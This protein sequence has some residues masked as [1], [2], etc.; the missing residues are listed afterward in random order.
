MGARTGEDPM[1]IGILGNAGVGKS[2]SADHLAQKWE[3]ASIAFADP[4]KRFCKEIFNFSVEQLWGPSE[5][6]N[7]ED[8][9]YP[10]GT[11]YLTPRHALQ[12]LGTQ[13]GRDCYP[14]VW[15]E[16]AIRTAQSI[17]ID[18]CYYTPERGA[19][20]A[21][22]PSWPSHRKGVVISDCRFPNEVAAIH[23]AGGKVIR[24]LRPSLKTSTQTH[25][26]ETEQKDIVVDE[27]IINDHDFEALYRKLDLF[28]VQ[29]RGRYA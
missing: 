10:R 28:I 25:A 2:V 17:L 19:Y 14:N 15:V 3:Y 21:V 11:G 4:M 13:W 29:H 6:R 23:R 26:S 18:H 9:R 20:H 7:K 22:Y 5:E 27:T 24:I 1:I 16:Y 12:Q 8:K